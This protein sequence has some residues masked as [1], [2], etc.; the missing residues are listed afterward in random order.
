M[1]R[2]NKAL[3]AAVNE[4]KAKGTAKGKEL[5][6]TGVKPATSHARTAMPRRVAALIRV[7]FGGGCAAPSAPAEGPI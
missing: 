6:I 2:L 5:V 4:L 3:T 1:E 7:E